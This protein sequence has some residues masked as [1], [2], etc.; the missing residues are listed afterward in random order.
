MSGRKKK[1]RERT[2]KKIEREMCVRE[3][4]KKCDRSGRERVLI[5]V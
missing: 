4:N 2:R 3:K 5:Q 1:V